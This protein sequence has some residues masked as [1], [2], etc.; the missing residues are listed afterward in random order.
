[1]QN[2][3]DLVFHTRPRLAALIVGGKEKMND[4]PEL[5]IHY[6]YSWEVEFGIEV[7]ALQ[8]T[9]GYRYIFMSVF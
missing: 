7:V 8:Y 2:N 3:V 4:E 5:K 1:M 6:D 9:S